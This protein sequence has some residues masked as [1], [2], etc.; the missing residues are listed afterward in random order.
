[1][2]EVGVAQL[3]QGLKGWL[4]R[5]EAGDEV[6]ITD[7]GRPIA[8]LTGIDA[9]TALERLIAEGRVSHPRRPRPHARGRERIRGTGLASASVIDERDAR[10]R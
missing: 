1:M 8:R 5:V 4:A 7:R 3:R 6:V 9:S 2:S 10:R